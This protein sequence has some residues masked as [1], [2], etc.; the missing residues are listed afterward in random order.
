VAA[1]NL[2]DECY[3]LDGRTV[4]MDST[5]ASKAGR[6]WAVSTLHGVLVEAGPAVTGPTGGTTGVVATRATRAAVKAIAAANRFDGMLVTVLTDNSMWR[7]NAASTLADDTAQEL[8]LEPDAGTGC[9]IRAD[10]AFVMQL[11]VA[12]GRA[13]G[14]TIETILEGFALRLA[15]LP[16]WEVTTSWAGG[17]S[18]AIGIA[19]NKT[20]YTAAGAVL[21][22]AAGDV[23]ATLDA[24]VAAGTIGT[25]FD[26]LAELQAALFVEGDTFT[27]EE[28]TSAFTAGA[29][30]VCIPVVVALSP[31]TP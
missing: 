14:D 8:A 25:G 2:G 10:K 15:A 7:F 17:S 20:G 18:S 27:Y 24:G 23:A 11:P 9:W 3:I 1:S 16:Y 12:F 13:D 21:G 4:T 28:I 19:S 5:G 22:G 6:V 26:S 31:A 29:G 30:F